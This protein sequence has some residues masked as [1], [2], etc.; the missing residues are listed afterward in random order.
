[1]TTNMIVVY[2]CDICFVLKWIPKGHVLEGLFAHTLRGKTLPFRN[3]SY[4]MGS[5]RLNF[6]RPRLSAE[7]LALGHP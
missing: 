4:W 3:P 2:G 6:H 7:S 5:H 1:M